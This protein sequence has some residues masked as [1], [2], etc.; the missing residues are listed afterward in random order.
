MVPAPP[1]RPRSLLYVP[2][3]ERRMVAKAAVRGADVVVLDL[4]DGVHPEQ[5]DGARARL[6]ES[7]ES[8]RAGGGRVVVRVNPPETGAGHRDLE[9]AG[10]IAPEA[11]LLPKAEAVDAVRAA[12]SILGE[13]L[14]VWL[15]VE[16]A[17]GAAQV[18]DLAAE[19]GVEGLVFGS[20]DYR[21]SMGAA[22]S[23]DE[24]DLAFVR[25]RLVL[26][27]RAAGIGVWDAPW[28]AF[29]DLDGLRRS[30]R[31]AFELGFDGKSAVHP[32]Q[33]PEIHAAFRPSDE[34]RTWA[35]R[36]IA[37]V[38]EAD[39]AGASVAELDG[40]LVEKLHRRHACRLLRLDEAGPGPLRRN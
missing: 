25:S 3:S 16:T 1:L 29:R 14:P 27:A 12:R 17:R 2:A 38:E 7:C 35:E 19:P 13:R 15:M 22:G 36:V 10:A 40:V 9:T 4:E 39:R 33:I 5:K 20:A 26:A 21:L 34:Q 30:A 24:A 28:F 37:A 6:A 11:V 32:I 18:F 23:P 31:R 8:A